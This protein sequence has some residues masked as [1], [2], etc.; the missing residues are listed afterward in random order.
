MHKSTMYVE[1]HDFLVTSG[2][3]L[4]IDISYYKIH[5]S[6]LVSKRKFSWLVLPWIQYLL[7]SLLFY[8]RKYICIN[9]NVVE[10]NGSGME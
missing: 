3:I 8:S 1:D 4:P 10:S 9:M 2:K 5:L 7:P 6:T